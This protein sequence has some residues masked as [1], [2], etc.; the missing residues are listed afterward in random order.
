VIPSPAP[1]PRVEPPRQTP[2]GV[3]PA[4]KRLQPTR[5]PAKVPAVSKPAP[6][7][8]QAPVV[9]KPATPLA[10]APA[11]SKPAPK[12]APNKDEKEKNN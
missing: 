2:G 5:P 11:A 9:S 4:Q 10:K 3:N 12:P 6:P 8:V 7:P 1:A